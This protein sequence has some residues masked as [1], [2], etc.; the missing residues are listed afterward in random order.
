M[1]HIA[2]R[3]IMPLIAIVLMLA[4]V[5]SGC[6]TNSVYVTSIAKTG[7]DGTQDIYTIYYS[8]GSTDSFTIMNGTDG[9]DGKDVSIMD[10][11][12]AYQE[13]TGNSQLSFED[14]LGQYLSINTDMSAVISQ[15]L[16]STAKIYAEF[17]ETTTIGGGIGGILG[18]PSYSSSSIAIST[19]AA[20][21]YSMDEAEDGYTY[22]VTD[23]HVIYDNNAD[24]DK[25]G[26]S[27]IARSVYAYLYG[28]EGSPSAV[29]ENGDGQADTD[30]NGYTI[31]NYGDYAIPLEYVGGTITYD[32]AVLRAKTSDVKA[33]NENAQA[34]RLAQE[35]HVGETAIAIGN[36][37]GTGLSVTQG[38]ISTESEYITL[39][40]DDTA[41][42]Y[43]SVRIDTAL[44]S[45]NSGGGL[46]NKHGELIGIT[47]AGDSSDQN[48]NYAVPLEIVRGTADSIIFYAND[49]NTA[50]DGV[51]R[52]LLGVTVS[53]QNSKYVYDASSGY[54]NI[55][56]EVVIASVTDGSLAQT[57]GISEGDILTA[58]IING[59][60]YQ[61]DRSFEIENLSLTVRAN[62]IVQFVCTRDAQSF[63][64]EEYTVSYSELTQVE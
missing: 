3:L 19:G 1:K 28:S 13:Q 44:Y 29:D 50:T 26:G 59:T 31:Y 63:T 45:G 22:F 32:I 12:Q 60:K 27:K 2:K 6:D 52:L 8:D 30:A 35:Y 15:S 39:Q 7:S 9:E 23:Y 10:I 42:S 21:I 17:V 41:R 54:G 25:N 64:T 46:F 34:V 11:Y 62:D 5:L 56:E 43:R 20:V 14:F 18:R 53:T 61:I 48:I 51:S 16:Q 33:I 4:L 58:V 24:S 49:G 37:E 57:L 55:C 47:N 38:I 40:I 36:P